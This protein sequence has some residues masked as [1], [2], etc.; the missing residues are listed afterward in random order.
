MQNSFSLGLLHGAMYGIT[1]LTPWFIGFKRYVFEGQMKGLLTFAGLFVGQVSLVLLAFFGGTELL[2]LWY[3]VEPALIIFGLLA[4]LQTFQ[5]IWS[6]CEMP[7]PVKTRKEGLLYF[8]TGVFFALCNPG[9]SMMCS[10]LLLNTLPQNT[11]S[12]LSG[13][14]LF[15]TGLVASVLYIACLSPLGQRYFGEC[16]IARLRTGLEPNFDFF[17]IRVRYVRI[18]GLFTSLVVSIQLLGLTLSPFGMEYADILFGATPFQDIVSKRD[19]RW[20]E[21]EDVDPS[22]AVDDAGNAAKITVERLQSTLDPN[23][24]LHDRM[25]A[26]V[27]HDRPWALLER[28]NDLNERL[29]RT[30]ISD[31]MKE[32]EIKFYFNSGP[33]A[34]FLDWLHR[35]QFH[36][37]FTPEWEKDYEMVP[38][39][40]DRLTDIRLERDNLL[41]PYYETT[42]DLPR[43]FL[44]WA[45]Y[46]KD[47]DFNSVL[48]SRDGTEV[49]EEQYLDLQSL[50]NMKS[51]R[52]SKFFED[53]YDMP[54]RGGEFED[55]SIVTLQALPKEIHLPWDFPRLPAPNVPDI[56]REIQ[57]APKKAVDRKNDVQNNNAWFLDP[58]ALNQRFLANDPYP[59]DHPLWG[60]NRPADTVQLRVPNMTR[61]WWL[62]ED[63]VSESDMDMP[64]Q[65]TRDILVAKVK[66]TG[67]K[68]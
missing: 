62:G 13:F 65:T 31:S 23:T 53:T 57:G 38:E 46:D 64:Y 25:D 50:Q 52:Q 34:L 1:P 29:E 24:R 61:R 5:N 41:R 28:Y 14:L 55:F 16:N 43:P 30:G 10:Q 11:W 45:L 67:G 40:L 17:P 9:G 42:H 59:D 39:F 15:Y 48:L 49:T 56:E 44:P 18:L 58:V 36:L 54:H 63:G 2:W 37:M 21:S 27:S 12:Y 32:D 20:M 51:V 47:Y 6:P 26:H 7:E 66:P 4:L 68:N 35:T 8:G 19:M 3:Y 33:D 22:G 60:G